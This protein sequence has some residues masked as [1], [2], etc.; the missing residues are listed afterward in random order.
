[1]KEKDRAIDRLVDFYEFCKKIGWVK[2]RTEFENR[3]NLSHNYLYNSCFNVKSTVGCEQVR[4]IHA[5]FPELN[6]TWVITGKGTMLTEVPDEGYREAYLNLKKIIKEI[7]K[8][9]DKL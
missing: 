6:L 8:E 5:A 9:L 7:K 2:S 1:M 3:C 4:K